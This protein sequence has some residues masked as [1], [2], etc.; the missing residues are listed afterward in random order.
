MVKHIV[1]WKFK[2]FAESA[3]KQHNLLKAKALLDSLVGKIAEIQTFETGLDVS[4]GDQSFDLVLYSEFASREAL[5]SYQ[6]HEEHM[7]VFW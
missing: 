6:K 1:A 4:Q 3:D 2:D 5:A 7:R